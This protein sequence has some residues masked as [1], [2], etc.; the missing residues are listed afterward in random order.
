MRWTRLSSLMRQSFTQTTQTLTP[1][2]VPALAKIKGQ[3]KQ[4]RLQTVE[5]HEDRSSG[6]Q[7]EERENQMTNLINKLACPAV[8]AASCRH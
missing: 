8:F 4:V 3:K 1:E 2:A 5:D 7:G 6:L